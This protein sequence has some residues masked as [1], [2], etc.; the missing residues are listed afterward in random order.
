MAKR[1]GPPPGGEDD[2]G[3][4]KRPPGGTPPRSKAPPP[5]APPGA[6]PRP[7]EPP[8]KAP[9]RGAEPEEPD[10]LSE[11]SSLVFLSESDVRRLDGEGP[12]PSPDPGASR[13]PDGEEGGSA[14]GLTESTAFVFMNESD[15]R[16]LD[17][18]EPPAP[19]PLP[20]AGPKTGA[21]PGAKAA[22]GASAKPPGKASP[23]AAPR[24]VLPSSGAGDRAPP[25]GKKKAA[26]GL[27][28]LLLLGGAALGAVVGGYAVH[29][30]KE[31]ELTETRDAGDKALDESRAQ[32]RRDAD[33]V[34]R[35]AQGRLAAKEEELR[36]ARDELERTRAAMEEA[37]RAAAAE[38]R[39][40]KDD[41]QAAETTLRE[42]FAASQ[43]AEAKILDKRAKDR[44][45]RERLDLER[46]AKETIERFQAL[47]TEADRRHKA[48][49]E[50]MR[51][52]AKAEIL[53]REA[54]VR[55]QLEDEKAAFES[56]KSKAVE[57][58][59]QKLEERLRAEFEEERGGF[60]R[61][62]DG[63]GEGGEGIDLEEVVWEHLKG[64]LSGSAQYKLFAGFQ[65]SVQPLSDQV[66][67][68]GVFRLRYDVKLFEEVEALSSP[69][70][71]VIA[72]RVKVDSDELSRGYQDTFVESQTLRPTFA[73]E[74]LTVGAGF[75]SFDVKVGKMIVSWGT[76]DLWNPTD[77]VNAVD[78]ID[79]LDS[80]K[81]GVPAADMSFYPTDETRL[82][83]L[84][85]PAFTP[86]RTPPIGKRFNP[87]PPEGLFVPTPGGPVGPVPIAER[88]LPDGT[89][90]NVQ[91]AGRASTTIAG[92]DLSGT[93]VYGW[94]DLATFTIDPTGDPL[95]PLQV[96]PRYDRYHM[97]GGDIATTL[98]VFE[99]HAEA[100]QF[101]TEG[102]RDDDFLQYLVGGRYTTG[103]VLTAK[104][105]VRF[106]VE[107]ASEW[108]T[109][110]ASA[111]NAVSGSGFARAFKNTVLNRI[112]YKPF[113]ELE[114]QGTVAAILYGPDSFYFRPEAS[115][116]IGAHTKIRAGF[117]LM[118]GP[119]SS[120]FGSYSGE[121]RFWLS[122]K[123]T[124]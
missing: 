1:A 64:H 6:P 59:T 32:A 2:A 12:P 120:F 114:I 20:V 30:A 81:I 106:I 26:L 14:D 57:L 23:G 68:E 104:D 105:E 16:R 118:G 60:I 83:L 34:E 41:F 85:I 108:V 35:L 52:E 31:G 97:F 121:D 46:R 103:D 96:T 43:A 37:A 48:D 62:T 100:G 53:R 82:R 77:V 17:S 70:E 113:N 4:A 36:R 107:F 72:P 93:Y 33:A 88:D 80:E 102:N 51:R 122:L 115:Y 92:L 61:G 47:A 3:A 119:K 65:E 99:V 21:K 58:E 75:G 123:L 25:S 18:D 63:G 8:R 73:F 7:P 91:L 76:G 50:V 84:V 11:S 40:Q 54:L 74:E 117:D 124:F 110:E 38:L 79:F 66:R 10:D 5:Q 22:A 69:L 13:D 67:H 86:S 78:F 24:T 87:V 55:K 19:L 89:A 42:T 90:E 98:W 111:A 109:R 39:R 15:V 56:E 49:A 101:V 71:I 9:G 29:R 95:V 45:A 44:A 112:A 94:N 116:D 27:I 28:V